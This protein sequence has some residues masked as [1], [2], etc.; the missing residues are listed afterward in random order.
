MISS[1]TRAVFKTEEKGDKTE[2]IKLS[3]ACNHGLSS[4]VCTR[5]HYLA[6]HL[7]DTASSLL[8]IFGWKGM[9]I[10]HCACFPLEISVNIFFRSLCMTEAHC[11]SIFTVRKLKTFLLV[12]EILGLPF[13]D[14]SVQPVTQKAVCCAANRIMAWSVF[15]IS[16]TT[17]VAES[18]LSAAPHSVWQGTFFLRI[19]IYIFF[20]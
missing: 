6:E 16:W 12:W 11:K 19:E 13:L 20:Q 2:S 18:F 8:I 3:K 15:S 14:N 7:Q 10:L 9:Q 1:L 5:F 17:A 4:P